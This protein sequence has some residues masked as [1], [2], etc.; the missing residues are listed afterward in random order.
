MI[1]AKGE[2]Q[3]GDLCIK[4]KKAITRSSP[5]EYWNEGSTVGWS[6]GITRVVGKIPYTCN[7][8]IVV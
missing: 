2:S 4:G 3:I 6:F 5:I 8:L 7:C 1:C